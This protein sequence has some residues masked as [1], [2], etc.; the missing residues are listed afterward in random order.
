[1]QD[2]PHY[3]TNATLSYNTTNYAYK[4]SIQAGL[5]YGTDITYSHDTPTQNYTALIEDLHHDDLHNASNHG[6]TTSKQHSCSSA[7][8]HDPNQI[9]D[10]VLT[11]LLSSGSSQDVPVANPDILLSADDAH[12]ECM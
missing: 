1:M 6:L 10:S 9:P 8:S 2:D 4:T 3:G 12:K 5:H 7:V 11:D